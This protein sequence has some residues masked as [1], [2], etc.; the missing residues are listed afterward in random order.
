MR[1]IFHTASLWEWMPYGNTVITTVAEAISKVSK[2]SENSCRDLKMERFR[3]VLHSFSEGG[4]QPRSNGMTN[5]RKK[6]STAC[7]S[8]IFLI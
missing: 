6:I 1:T 4:W 8:Q 2:M 5:L 7:Q 3:L